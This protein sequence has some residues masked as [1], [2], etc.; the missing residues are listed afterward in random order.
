MGERALEIALTAPQSSSGTRRGGRLLDRPVQLSGC[1][2]ARRADPDRKR[3]P[4]GLLFPG[5]GLL[6]LMPRRVVRRGRGGA[7]VG[8]GGGDTMPLKCSEDDVRKI[9]LSGRDIMARPRMIRCERVGLRVDLKMPP[10]LL[11]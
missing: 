10:M 7:N 1:S 9:L 2:V 5:A 8:G 6:M 3:P 4:D 11:Q